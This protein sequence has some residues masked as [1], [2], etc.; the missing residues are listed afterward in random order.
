MDAIQPTLYPKS[1][2]GENKIVVNDIMNK[3]TKIG[4]GVRWKPKK[5]DVVLTPK[6][7]AELMIK[8]CDIKPT[9]LVLDP[10]R[11]EGVFF[12]NLPE[13]S[14][15][16]CEITEDID[17]FEYN[18]PVDIICGNPPYSR[19]NDWIKHTLKLNPSKF[20]YIFGVY[21]LTP[22]RLKLIFDGGYIIKKFHLCSVDWWYSP[23]FL[24][25]FEKGNVEDSIVS[26]D[27][28]A[29]FCDICINPEFKC[30]RG[31]TQTINGVKKK[32]GANECSNFKKI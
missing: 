8:M 18:K 14:K 31:R 28:K 19:W 22:P 29:Y 6:L 10:S 26:F 27:P 4:N 7:V 12:N 30:M 20:C 3:M 1:I 5:N 2:Y 11:G 23:S 21:N 16:Y 9:D 25:V 15:D 24:V 17:F 13:C 32:W